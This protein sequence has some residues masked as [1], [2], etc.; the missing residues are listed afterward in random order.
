M[1]RHPLLALRNAGGV[2]AYRKGEPIVVGQFLADVDRVASCMPLGAHVLNACADR[3]RFA[4][5]LA[6]AMVADKVSVLPSNLAPET[7]GFLRA[8][9][10]DLVCLT[11][12]E[13]PQ[14]G[15][16]CVSYRELCGGD[17]P[18]SAVAMPDFDADQAT[19]WLFT[20]GSTGLPIAHLKTWGSLVRSAGIEAERFGLRAAEGAVIVATVPPQ[21]AYG[22]ESSVLLA[23]HGGATFSAARP[24]YPVDI[25]AALARKKPGD[26]VSIVFVDRAGASRTGR[27]TLGEDPHLEVVP[28]E[29]GGTLT[30][31]QR[32]F[33]DRWLGAR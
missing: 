11:D 31:A 18:S 3:Y 1:P 12:G 33:R 26:I 15:L 19:A 29:Q 5:V 27:A 17:P 22:L 16:P 9:H 10:A 32:A 4:V 30:P 14:L 6:A 20:S 8:R 25:S 28:V 13:H 24:F 23:L 7:I 21:H 2:V